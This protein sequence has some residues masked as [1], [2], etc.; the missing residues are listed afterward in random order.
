MFPLLAIG[1]NAARN[2]GVQVS[3]L[4]SLLSFILS[5]NPGLELVDHMVLLFFLFKNCHIG[6]HSSSTILQ[7]HWQM[8]E[9]SNFS[10]SCQHLLLSFFLLFVCFFYNRHPNWC[11][12]AS[13]CDFHCICLMISDLENLV[14]I[15]WKFKKLFFISVLAYQRTDVDLRRRLESF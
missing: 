11:E 10:T 1:S 15:D 4:V 2:V 6:F 9:G 3:V 14:L 5:I 13:H 12:I 7:S 8:H